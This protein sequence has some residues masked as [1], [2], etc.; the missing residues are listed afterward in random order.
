VRPE[1]SPVTPNDFVY[2]LRH[3]HAGGTAP[4]VSLSSLSSLGKH[5]RTF[6]GKRRFIQVKEDQERSGLS[7][8]IAGGI[9]QAHN[10]PFFTGRRQT[11]QTA[12]EPP[13]SN[14]PHFM[15]R[16]EPAVPAPAAL[17]ADRA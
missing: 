8:Q 16:K 14:R 7:L 3:G 1:P 6:R 5:L 10:M 13:A 17:N 11:S 2:L 12:A 9:L 4:V 15:S